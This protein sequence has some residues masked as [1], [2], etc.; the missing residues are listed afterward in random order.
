MRLCCLDI[1]VT[2]DE[3]EG[4][5]I[6]GVV[7]VCRDG[8][9]GTTTFVAGN[10]RRMRSAGNFGGRSVSMPLVILAVALMTKPRWEWG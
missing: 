9:D 6:A 5:M 7:D 4:M 2:L 8:T 10:P 1:G 3:G